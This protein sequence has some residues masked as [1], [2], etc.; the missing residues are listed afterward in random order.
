M[1][2]NHVNNFFILLKRCKLFVN[3]FIEIKLRNRDMIKTLSHNYANRDILTQILHAFVAEYRNPS[4][5]M[6]DFFN[7]TCASC[8]ASF[9]NSEVNNP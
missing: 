9:N 1:P 2:F 8:L 3:I 4:I 7:F 5:L 6:K